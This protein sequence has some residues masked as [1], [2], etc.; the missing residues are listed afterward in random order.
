MGTAAVILI[1]AMGFGIWVRQAGSDPVQSAVPPPEPASKK[2]LADD[3][4]APKKVPAHDPFAWGEAVDGVE[5]G[6]AFK[7]DRKSYHLGESVTFVFKARNVS[8]KPVQ[9]EQLAI[10]TSVST[11]KA[12]QV[13]VILP[14]V[15]DAK[16]KEIKVHPMT[17]DGDLPLAFF[18]TIRLAPKE[19][20]TLGE[21][22]YTLG[23][24]V[25]LPRIDL[26]PG[27]YKVQFPTTSYVAQRPTG[28]L[29]MTVL[30][31]KIKRKPG[32]VELFS[33]LEI[34]MARDKVETLLGKPI[35][36]D[37][38]QPDGVEVNYLGD[39]FRERVLEMQESPFLPAGIY[40]TY[41]DGKLTKKSFNPQWLR[42]I[43]WGKAVN[44]VEYGLALQHNARQ[45]R[46]GEKVTLILHARNTTGRPVRFEQIEITGLGS[47]FG[48]TL[49]SSLPTVIDANG[50]TVKVTPQY[51]AGL[52]HQAKKINIDLKEKGTAALGE[53]TFTIGRA[54]NNPQIDA[55]PGLYFLHFDTVCW[56][57]GHQRPTG[58]MEILVLP[59]EK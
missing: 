36:K 12:D 3:P 9:F 17:P 23:A 31:A 24:G 6:V 51:L 42:K 16:G 11:T 14:K 2:V 27:T 33:K 38:K 43:A 54:D 48:K 32:L 41:V 29:E 35:F 49:G 45:Y 34:G 55:E 7:D 44:G 19:S 26:T 37:L 21:A 20:A 56:I 18:R 59:K 52:P 53:V 13:G 22:S 10:S 1:A 46:V 4:I 28:V 57:P 15:H 25:Q 47:S 30:E 5:Y 39:E 58:V 40:L 8:A 50:K